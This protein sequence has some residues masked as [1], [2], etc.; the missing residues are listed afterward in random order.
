MSEL[1][2]NSQEFD[3]TGILIIS[4]STKLFLLELV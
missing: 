4:V 1:Q 2:S 3:F